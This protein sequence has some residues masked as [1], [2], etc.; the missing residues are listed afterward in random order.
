M[1]PAEAAVLLTIAAAYDNRKPDADQAKAWAMALDGLRFEDCRTVIV[2]HY[3][4]SREWLMPVDVV[5]G[6][7]RLRAQRLDDY[8]PIPAPKGI[9]P[10]DKPRYQRARLEM[11]TRIADGDLV[12]QEEP[13]PE[14]LPARDVIR[15]LGHIGQAVDEGLAMRSLRDA[16]AEAKRELQVAEADRKRA[17]DARR[18]EL[19]RMRLEDQAARDAIHAAKGGTD[20]GGTA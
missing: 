18:A 16:H 14:A 10:D 15:E 4:K 20:E 17:E 1:K 8:G 2:E 19:E 12:R 7:K 6:V 11:Q 13:E 9:D 5:M 3:R